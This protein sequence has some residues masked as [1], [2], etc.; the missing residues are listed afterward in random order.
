MNPWPYI[1]KQPKPGQ[2]LIPIDPGQPRLPPPAPRD[3]PGN[4]VD[5]DMGT[6]TSTA[7]ATT[8]AAAP[9]GGGQGG[10]QYHETQVSYARPTYQLQDTHTTILP[11]YF[12]FSF[13]G[14]DH[15]GGVRITINCTNIL[16]PFESSP[17][18]AICPVTGNIAKGV[19]L[20]MIP[21]SATW[22]ATRQD[23]VVPSATT[24]TVDSYVQG[25]KFWSKIYEYYTVTKCHYALRIYPN[26]YS[27]RKKNGY[28]MGQYREAFKKT[29]RA[30][31]AR[32]DG[33]SLWKMKHQEGVVWTEKLGVSLADG[34]QNYINEYDG[35]YNAGSVKTNVQNDED[36]KTWHK[37]GDEPDLQE[38]HN[39]VFYRPPTVP[40]NEP[41]TN[42]RFNATLEVKY[43]VQYKDRL[44]PWRF[45]DGSG[46]T[47]LAS[48]DLVSPTLA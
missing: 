14:L 37:I 5:H 31:Q 10:K 44:H 23:G 4:E 1:P 45:F 28:M 32:P 21:D 3:P 43:V 27:D 42:F 40:R 35:S 12:N 6:G 46:L 15:T 48:G 34:T 29:E 20:G 16:N 38:T 26:A 24:T 33:V 7:T 30:N 11:M 9:A 36:Q 19:F 2:P 18:L 47:S 17:G 13:A 8:A 22:P 39:F 41:A 25:H